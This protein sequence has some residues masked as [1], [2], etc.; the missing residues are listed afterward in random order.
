MKALL[1]GL[2]LLVACND[3][4]ERFP[5]NPGGGG[6]TGGNG[7]VDAATEGSDDGGGD[8]A[9]GGRVCLLVD[10]TQPTLCADT[11]AENL[12]VTLGT[13]S[14]MTTTADGRFTIVKPSGSNLVWR[15]SGDAV[16]PSAMSFGTET[17]IPA[18]DINVFE[19]MLDG[20]F[21]TL[22]PNDGQIIARVRRG[23]MALSAVTAT[24]VPEADLPVLYDGNTPE[25]WDPNATG[26]RGVIWVPGVSSSSAQLVVHEGA[27]DLA[28]INGIPLFADTVTFV[29]ADF[30]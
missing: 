10:A 14:V 22:V 11:G 18:I 21:V 20:S 3:D 24:T 9:I 16:F 6:G 1:A 19:Q 28:P 29:F 7:F 17:T 12:L 27:N 2:L 23:T 8:N 5:V 25:S 4:V 26:D 30:P 15:V 13:E